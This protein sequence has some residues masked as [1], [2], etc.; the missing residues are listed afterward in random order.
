M[1]RWCFYCNM[2][3][4]NSIY[5]AI[6]MMHPNTRHEHCSAKAKCS[7]C[8][9][10]KYADTAFWLCRAGASATQSGRY[11]PS[12]PRGHDNYWQHKTR[13]H[14]TT[15]KEKTPILLQYDKNDLFYNMI[16]ND[17]A[18]CIVS[19]DMNG[20]NWHS[21]ERQMQPLI[22]NADVITTDKF[23]KQRK[24]GAEP[25]SKDNLLSTQY[26]S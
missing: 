13:R 4:D 9:L 14:K 3:N 12:Y 16:K 23:Y 19:P 18:L 24:C 8:L 15:H 22:S 6:Y 1:I 5:N 26:D 25:H 17:Y 7:I 2:T 11:S 20:C 10:V 21:I